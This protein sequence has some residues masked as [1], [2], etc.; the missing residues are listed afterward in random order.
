MLANDPGFRSEDANLFRGRTLTYFGR[1][2]Y[3]YEEASRQ[4]AVGVLIVHETDAAGYPWSVVVAGRCASL[5][6]EFVSYGFLSVKLSDR[7]HVNM[8]PSDKNNSR[9]AM[10]GWITADEARRL[11]ATCGHDYDALKGKAHTRQHKSFQLNATISMKITNQVAFSFAAISL[12]FSLHF[13]LRS[14]SSAAAV[15]LVPQFRGAH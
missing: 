7:P 6:G 9:V 11:L 5:G 2:T 4:G 12:S 1:W 14:C 8:V 13:L 3:K 10:E 15:L